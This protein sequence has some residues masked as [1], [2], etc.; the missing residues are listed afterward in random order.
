MKHWEYLY[1]ICLAIGQHRPAAGMVID[2]RGSRNQ[3]DPRRSKSPGRA[4]ASE[5]ACVNFFMDD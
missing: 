1:E 5:E 3:Y 2:K 4:L